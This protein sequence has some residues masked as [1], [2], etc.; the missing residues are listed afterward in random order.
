M[1]KGLQRIKTKPHMQAVEAM[2]TKRLDAVSESL[3]ILGDLYAEKECPVSFHP[4][5]ALIGE[6]REK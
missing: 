2:G 5:C 6:I 4:V 3:E 1:L